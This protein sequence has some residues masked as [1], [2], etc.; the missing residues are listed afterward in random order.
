M[1][2]DVN[3][4]IRHVIYPLLEVLSLEVGH[5]QPVAMRINFNKPLSLEDVTEVHG[6]NT[7]GRNTDKSSFYVYKV[8]DFYTTFLDNSRLHI[9]VIDNIRKRSRANPRGKIKQKIKLK[10]RI[11][12]SL[13]FD[14]TLYQLSPDYNGTSSSIVKTSISDNS[15]KMRTMI[16]QTAG[17]SVAELPMVE[18][19]KTIKSFYQYLTIE[20]QAT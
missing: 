14:K 7:G 5:K 4:N 6:E 8:L 9:N 11:I 13:S 17:D 19:L 20:A 2:K 1:L 12:I 18:L 16:K 15:I 10:R 3:N